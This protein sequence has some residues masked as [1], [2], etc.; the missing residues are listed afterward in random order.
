MGKAAKMEMPDTWNLGF[1][2]RIGPIFNLF[3]YSTHPL[4]NHHLPCQTKKS[5]KLK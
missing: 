1:V 4:D 3:E 2:R 5:N